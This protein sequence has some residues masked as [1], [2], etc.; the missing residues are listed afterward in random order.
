MRMRVRM[1]RLHEISKSLG[2]EPNSEELVIKQIVNEFDRV[3]RKQIQRL[4]KGKFAL[5]PQRAE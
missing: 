2:T 1:F 4:K 5:M 3:S